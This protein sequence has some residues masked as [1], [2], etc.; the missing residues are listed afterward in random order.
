MQNSAQL[1][2]LATLIPRPDGYEEPKNW[3]TD[4]AL[5][6]IYLLKENKTSTALQQTL[7]KLIDST[8]GADS[9]EVRDVLS[10]CLLFVIELW[11]AEFIL[12]PVSYKSHVATENESYV[13]SFC[14]PLNLI[15]LEH[16]FRNSKTLLTSYNITF[17]SLKVTRVS[18]S[19]QASRDRG[20][21]CC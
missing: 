13:H 11:V 14:W 4:S 2:F 17:V 9:S 19:D 16:K 15:S 1:S 3:T 5:R 12:H 6:L 18:F 10:S 8:V 21:I 7:S 20:A